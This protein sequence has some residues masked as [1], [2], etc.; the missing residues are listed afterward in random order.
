MGLSVNI[1]SKDSGKTEMFCPGYLRLSKSANDD[2]S[3]Y[4]LN[5]RTIYAFTAKG[6]D[7]KNQGKEILK[8]EGLGWIPS[9]YF[10]VVEGIIPN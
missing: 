1:L 7:M 2:G 9:S 10:E 5:S 6:W 3:S 8:I 4:G